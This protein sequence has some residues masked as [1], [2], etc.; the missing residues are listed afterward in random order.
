MKK[1]KLRIRRQ[2]TRQ[3]KKVKQTMRIINWKCVQSQKRIQI[4]QRP[5]WQRW[6]PE[7]TPKKGDKNVSPNEAFLEGGGEWDKLPFWKTNQEDK[8]KTDKQKQTSERFLCKK[9]KAPQHN[10][11]N[12]HHSYYSGFS[13]FYVYYNFPSY[14]S[15]SF[16]FSLL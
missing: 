8:R 1:P 12:S 9:S 14:Y 15:F 6:Q 4:Q 5:Q 10:E 11:T 3:T 13:S 16:S 7:E 2:N